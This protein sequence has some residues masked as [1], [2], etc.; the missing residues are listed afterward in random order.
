MTKKILT[1][2][3]LFVG[4]IAQAQVDFSIKI[5][6]NSANQITK[7]ECCPDINYD[8]RL[9]GIFGV[10]ADIMLK[11]N[12]SLGV[13]FHYTSNGAEFYSDGGTYL[14]RRFQYLE[15]PVVIKYHFLNKFNVHAGTQLGYLLRAELIIDNPG[16]PPNYYDSTDQINRLTLSFIGGLEYNPLKK[17]G[18]GMRYL[19]GIS[20]LTK[21]SSTKLF[22]KST[23]HF[24]LKYQIK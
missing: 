11:S 21:G 18:V 9:S 1:I 13:D 12:F 20:D 6:L 7:F 8:Q 23:Y 16:S 10:A 19:T 4:I 24:Y 2:L 3:L 17:V 15:L 22:L 5:G 14:D